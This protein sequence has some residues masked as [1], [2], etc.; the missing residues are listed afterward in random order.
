VSSLDNL[1]KEAKRRLKTLR[2]GD[3][4]ATLR[5]VQQALAREHGFGDWNAMSQALRAAA[6][7]DALTLVRPP[8]A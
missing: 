3:P 5:S 4:R 7:G 8:C 6:S 1:K 2:A